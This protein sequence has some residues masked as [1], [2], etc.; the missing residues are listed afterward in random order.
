MADT[1]Q[2]L[3][4]FGKHQHAKNLARATIDRRR[5]SLRS[6]ARFAEPM[7][8]LDVTPEL[9]EEW[10]GSYRRAETAHAYLADARAFFRW[11]RRRGM[12]ERDPCEEVDPVRRPKPLPRPIADEDLIRSLSAADDRLRLVLL[13]GDLAG[14]RRAEIARLRGEDCSAHALLVR[15]GKGGKS[16][17]VPMHPYLWTLI[18][19]WGIEHGYLFESR[20]GGGCVNPETVG[21][22]VREHHERLG[23]AARLHSTRHHYGTA[24]ARLANG[25]VLA[26]RD[27]MGHSSTRTTEGYIA[28]DTSGLAGLVE[29]LGVA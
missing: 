11:A 17:V 3:E 1:E 13:L 26:V 25:N 14:L 18:R 4:A 9:L 7:G 16:R 22:W 12:V 24:L 6:L 5:T 19:A 27:L 29:Q 2:L 21:R 20:R 23:I 28:F 10:V 8:L 15:N